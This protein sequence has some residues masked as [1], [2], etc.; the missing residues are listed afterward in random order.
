MALIDEACA[1]GARRRKACELLGLNMRTVE[2]WVKCPEDGR[3]GPHSP[4]KNKLTKE[5]RDLVIK[6]SNCLEY[7]NLA[8]WQIVA[9]LAD[10]GQY[11]ASES[12]F[13]RIL[14]A[15]GLMAHRS[16]AQPPTH[17]KPEPLVAIKPNSIWSW[18]ITYLPATRPCTFY[19]LYLVLDIFSRKVVHHE[20]NERE[21]AELAAEMITKACANNNINKLQ[22]TLHSDNGGPMKGAPM[23]ATLQWLGIT[24][25]FSRPKVSNDNPYS[26]SQFRTLKY[27]PKWPKNGFA[28]IEDARAWVE[29]FVKWYN[30][31]H[32]HSGIN[33]VTPDS[34]HRGED[35]EILNKRHEVYIKAKEKAPLRW[36]GKTRNWSPIVKVE[37]NPGREKK[38]K[39]KLAVKKEILTVPMA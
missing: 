22:L 7:A 33:W 18:D 37:L 34:R 19:Y 9:R 27:C 15:E 3:C 16:R 10:K 2:R 17:K 25:S 35:I 21:S 24:T 13:Y 6:T 5:E 14:N 23:L 28:S 4:P 1:S 36:S 38:L 12:S 31:E 20:V 32:L 30:T 39:Q 29:K 11:L 8:P 26:E